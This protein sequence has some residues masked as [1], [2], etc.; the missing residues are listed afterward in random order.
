[1]SVNLTISI[2]QLYRAQPGGI[3]TYVRG[4]AQG[5]AA[6]ADPQL[7]VSGLAPRGPS[8]LDVTEL[9]LRVI[10]APLSLAVLT[11]TW[12]YWPLGV[13][14]DA[15]IVHATS[16]AG[17]FAGGVSGAVHSVAMHDLLWRD[18]PSAS[19]SAGI[20]FHDQRLRLIAARGELRVLTSSPGLKE[21]LVEMGFDPS[22]VHPVRLG[23]DDDGVGA[24]PSDVIDEFLAQRGVHGPFTLYAGT[25]EPRK[26]IERL[27]EAHER[28]VR[29]A[30]GLGRLVLAGPPGWGDVPTRDAIVVG[31]VPRSVLKGLYRDAALFAYVP[32]A[33]GWGL[34]PVEALYLG[35]RVVASRSTPSVAANSEVVRVD[36]LDVDAIAQGLL[37]GVALDNDADA[38]SRR[39]ASVEG[40]TW[41]NAAIDHMAG[42]R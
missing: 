7:R 16:M 25:R 29:E 26:N 22:R 32:R 9:P 14:R 8:G 13:P 40:L 28:A 3:G 10:A 33:E 39:R 1:M 2:D 20:R 6:L 12:R 34:P 31:L 35:T 38:A 18:E 17:P 23:V 30:P 24:A 19:T 5:L 42:W 27:V 37:D 36:P 4:L 15:Q 11:R 41:R 21:R